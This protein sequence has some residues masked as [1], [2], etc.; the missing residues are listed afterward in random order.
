MAISVDE[1][2]K[3]SGRGGYI[4]GKANGPVTRYIDLRN[5]R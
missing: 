3:L 2:T 1:H 5:D 4:V